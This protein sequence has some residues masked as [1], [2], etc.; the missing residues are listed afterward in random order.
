VLAASDQQFRLSPKSEPVFRFSS[1]SLAMRTDRE[2]GGKMREWDTPDGN[3]I[4]EMNSQ[5][6]L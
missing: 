3:F 5:R 6:R 2:I 4:P 1:A